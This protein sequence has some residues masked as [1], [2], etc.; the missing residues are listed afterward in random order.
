MIAKDT[1]EDQ[2]G[3][4]RIECE[5]IDGSGLSTSAKSN[6]FAPVFVERDKN[7]QIKL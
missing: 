6:T 5:T 4:H 1:M 2:L 7:N 3:D